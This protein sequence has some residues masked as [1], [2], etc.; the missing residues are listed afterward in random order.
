MGGIR[1]KSPLEVRADLA[2]ARPP[3]PKR[4]L[5]KDLLAFDSAIG[6]FICN[7]LYIVTIFDNGF[8]VRDWTA[9]D[10]ISYP[11]KPQC[12]IYNGYPIGF[13]K[14]IVSV[15]DVR[16]LPFKLFYI[17]DEQSVLLH[18][19]LVKLSE[20]PS[21]SE[22]WGLYTELLKTDKTGIYTVNGRKEYI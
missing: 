18:G 8:L 15:F 5:Y 16:V 6:A 21:L 17:P 14:T 13:I 11:G 12:D 10:W 2:D 4:E 1:F 20:A 22:D 7:N 3:V 9:P 19:K